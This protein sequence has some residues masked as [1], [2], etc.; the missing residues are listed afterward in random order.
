MT[1]GG[2][3]PATLKQPLSET[4]PT[5]SGDY[6]GQRYSRLSQ[7]NRETVKNLTLNWTIEVSSN[8][9]GFSPAGGGGGMG[10]RGGSPTPPVR[11]IVGGRTVY[12]HVSAH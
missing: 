4:W 3:D 9:P 11:T 1:Q 12:E 8:V 10:G 2:L 7:I 5:Y 6:S